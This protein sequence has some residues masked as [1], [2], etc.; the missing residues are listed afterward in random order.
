MKRL[1]V[2]NVRDIRLN[3][4]LVPLLVI[5]QFCPKFGCLFRLKWDEFNLLSASNFNFWHTSNS[6]LLLNVC[7]L[8]LKSLNPRK[9]QLD[10][11]NCFWF[12]FSF[13]R[14]NRKSLFSSRTYNSCFKC[15][16]FNGIL[17]NISPVHLEINRVCPLTMP[18]KC[19]KF[20]KH[21]CEGLLWILPISW[22][23]LATHTC[24][25]IPAQQGCYTPFATRCAI[26]EGI[27]IV[28][29]PFQTTQYIFGGSYQMSLLFHLLL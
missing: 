12:H 3:L 17:I 27:K 25:Y 14:G 18:K 6:P 24:T 2:I 15:C 11:L 21:S 16:C 29:Y 10:D 7:F 5:G 1:S 26:C 19:T 13:T 9:Y 23:G 20:G 8:P 22:S 4:R 28:T